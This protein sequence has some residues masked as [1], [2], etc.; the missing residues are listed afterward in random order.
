[1]NAPTPLTTT[2]P[3]DLAGLRLDQALTSLF[4]DYSRSRLQNWIRS[5][6]ILIDGARQR[7]KERVKGGET[8]TLD[9]EPEVLSDCQ[10]QN[11]PLD[12]VYQDEAMLIVNKPV[13]LVVHPAAGNWDNTL[14]NALLHFDSSLAAIPRAGIIHRIDK[15]TSG[16]LMIARTLQ[17]HRSLTEQLQARTIL[18]EYRAIVHGRMT[19]GGTINAPL[20]RHPTDRKRQAVRM[21]NYVTGGLGRA[22]SDVEDEDQPGRE[23][24]THYRVIKRFPN[25]TLISVRLETGRTHQI[26][27]HMA[28]I[29]YPLVGDPMYGGRSRFPPGADPLLL[30]RLRAFRHQALHA[31]RLGLV[32]PTSG[33]ECEWSV[34]P[35]DDM[36]QLL[37]TLEQFDNE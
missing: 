30:D 9:A 19:G 34:E 18:R 13:G 16:L 17:A 37:A 29:R 26:R 6:R 24:I 11:I 2:I 4:P 36:Q 33:D 15:E 21:H 7:P 22:A 20:G 32:H 5:G 14:Q 27:V 12:I 8:I 35:P 28:H 25:H 23:A 31:A 10:P 1:M 3:D